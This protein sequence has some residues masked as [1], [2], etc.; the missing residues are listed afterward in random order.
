MSKTGTGGFFELELPDGGGTGILPFWQGTNR[1]ACFLNA[2]SALAALVATLKPGCVWLPAYLCDSLADAVP[3]GQR[4]YYPVAPALS[5]AVAVLRQAVAGDMV[6][7]INYFGSLPAQDFLDFTRERPD[8]L[9]VEDCAHCL[10]PAEPAWGHWRLFSP[11]KLVGVADGGVLVAMNAKLPLPGPAQAAKHPEHE[12]R[13]ALLRF[14][15][16]GMERRAEWHAAS[17]QR[18]A[19]AAI[20][21]EAMT[22]LSHDLLFR[23]AAEPRITRRSDNYG[24]L[25]ERLSDWFF[26]P[27]GKKTGAPF[28]AILRVDAARRDTI[29][30]G[31]HSA[32]I[33]AATHWR[34]MPSPKADFPEEHGLSQELISL[35]CDHRYALGDM[36]RLADIAAGLL[37]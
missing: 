16:S 25:S 29:L 32:G 14:E 35:P 19:A 20:T 7:G 1:A 5:P 27:A 33:F 17:Q 10:A 13:A 30:S 2:R 6:V 8:L 37:G 34:G 26:A 18:E 23:L 36:H 15:D 4:R 31:L 11:R 3:A 24:A 9:F 21:D 12:W 22:R 28:A